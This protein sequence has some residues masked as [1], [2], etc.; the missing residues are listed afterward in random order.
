M[1]RTELFETAASYIAGIS[2]GL[3]FVVLYVALS[4][5]VTETVLKLIA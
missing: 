4:A 3:A 1:N 5:P 2:T